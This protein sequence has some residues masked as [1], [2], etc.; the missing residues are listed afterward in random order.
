MRSKEDGRLYAVKR[1][2]ER[3][4]GESDRLVVVVAKRLLV[5]STFLC[6]FSLPHWIVSIILIDVQAKEVGGSGE[7]R[8]AAQA[9]ELC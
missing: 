9:S 6:W 1:S 8:E 3:F 4:R 7:A 5:R 2:R